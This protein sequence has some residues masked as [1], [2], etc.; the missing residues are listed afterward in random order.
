MIR[1]LGDG[2]KSATESAGRTK[3][4]RKSPKRGPRAS[5]LEFLRSLLD[6]PRPVSEGPVG[7]CTKRGW[8]RRLGDEGDLVVALTDLGQS[9]LGFVER[10]DA[11][12][13]AQGCESN[14]GD[15]L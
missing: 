2:Q 12:S 15:E 13:L 5:E 8:C 11:N 1:L 14:M 10:H 7:R 9:M 6:G 4:Q 3:Y